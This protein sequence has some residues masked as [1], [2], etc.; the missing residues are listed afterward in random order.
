MSHTCRLTQENAAPLDIRTSQKF[1][2][3]NLNRGGVHEESCIDMSKHIGVGLIY[4]LEQLLASLL[5]A[6][7]MSSTCAAESED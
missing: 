3:Q 2:R 5:F 4:V 7:V 1:H 6:I